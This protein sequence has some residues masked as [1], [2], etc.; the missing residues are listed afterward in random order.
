MLHDCIYYCSSH[1]FYDVSHERLK[2]SHREN[3]SLYGMFSFPL[4]IWHLR[5]EVATCLL[6][7]FPGPHSLSSLRVEKFEGFL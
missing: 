2:D 3:T 1:K 7:T 4:F 5:L 6:K